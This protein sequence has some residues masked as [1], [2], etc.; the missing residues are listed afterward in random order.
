MGPAVADAPSSS[1]TLCLSI[2]NGHHDHFMFTAFP[3]SQVARYVWQLRSVRLL[4]ILLKR[5]DSS[6]L[7]I[8]P[9]LRTVSVQETCWRA[10][11]SVIIVVNGARSSWVPRNYNPLVRGSQEWRLSPGLS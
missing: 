11:Y 3:L 4:M 1:K 6:R 5:R 2:G 7:P 8:R 10:S 9:G